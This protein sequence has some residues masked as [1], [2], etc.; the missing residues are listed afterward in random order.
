M[1]EY[2]WTKPSPEYTQLPL[3]EKMVEDAERRLGVKLP[4]AYIDILHVQNGGPIRYNTF[5]TPMP[6]Q[7]GSGQIGI[8]GILGIG[9]DPM[10]TILGSSY[11]IKEWGMP[12]DLIL[13]DGDG[14]TWIALDYRVCGSQGEPSV[15]WIDNELE[16]LFRNS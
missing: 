1:R 12:N 16:Q 11:F 4:A 2:F 7:T 13:L 14:H 5:F 9:P 15:V 3:T 6:M 8:S 10:H